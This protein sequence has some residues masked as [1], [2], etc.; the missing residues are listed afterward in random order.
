[1]R[2]ILPGAAL[3]PPIEH[4]DLLR[5]GAVPG[6]VVVIIDGYYHQRAPVRHKEILDL[7]AGGVVVIGCASMGALR[8]AE[9]GEYGMIGH[10]A[11]YRMYRDGV[12]DADDEVALAHTPAP[13]YRGLTVPSVVVRHLVDDAVRSGLLTDAERGSIIDV[14][15]GIHYTE[16][17]WQAIWHAV[18]TTDSLAD[19]RDR[20]RK[21]VES[22][23]DTTDIKA[24][25]A[26]DTLRK[27]ADGALSGN[28]RPV[29]SW[30]SGPWANRFLEEW[31]AEFA[32]STVDDIEVGH[33]V[34]IRYQQLYL[35]DF[36]SRWQRFA[37]GR[38]AGARAPEPALGELALATAARHGIDP[39]AVTP[40]WREHWLTEREAAELPPDAALLRILVR[41]YRQWRPA[42]ELIADQPDLVEDVAARR[43]VAEA[44]VVNA[45]VASWGGK[46]SIDYLKQAVLSA[47]LA[48]VWQ[49][50]DRDQRV[51]LA[52][53]RDRGFESID[54]AIGAARMFFL[55]K[56]FLAAQ[57][58][59]AG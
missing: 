51:L 42:P 50:G 3:H 9:L 45:E 47:H 24:Q 13:D 43:A 7:L 41:S 38:I 12:L 32:V 16:R 44:V 23:A 22:N 39:A 35:D 48:Q 28:R 58:S 18:D 33:G 26:L 1:M 37:L 59:R 10:G 46:Q 11:V 14:V 57:A 34:I 52:A 49:V 17:S 25:D 27:I 5:L 30:V 8:A 55:H 4:G 56:K 31:H 54:D 29:E 6:D 2:K 20:L 19:V 40:A 36:P 21:F 15:R 53:A